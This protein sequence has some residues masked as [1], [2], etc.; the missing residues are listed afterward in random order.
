M[1]SEKKQSDLVRAFVAI[2]VNEEVRAALT[3]TQRKLK[4]SDAHVSWVKAENIHLSLA[5]LGDIFPRQVKGMSES[6]DEIG[7]TCGSFAMEVAGVGSFGAA[8]KPRV[9]WAG[10]EEPPEELIEIQGYVATAAEGLGI[11]VDKRPFRPHITLGRVRSGRNVDA[12]TSAMASVKNT[13]HGSVEVRRILLMRS[14]LK[15]QGAEYSILHE[16]ALK[17]D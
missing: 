3:D 1:T 7:E 2:E 13:R 16:T 5:F 14:V 8:Q 10:I 12:L 11:P 15:P 9:I 6:L 17:G 4:K